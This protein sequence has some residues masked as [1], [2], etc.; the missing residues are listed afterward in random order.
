MCLAGLRKT[1]NNLSQNSRYSGQDSNGLFLEHKSEALPLQPVCTV[2]DNIK[3]DVRNTWYGGTGGS[4]S[5]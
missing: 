5:S 4:D 1:A 3:V 2:E